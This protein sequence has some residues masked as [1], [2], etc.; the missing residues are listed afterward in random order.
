MGQGLIGVEVGVRDGRNALELLYSL[1]IKRLY[2]VDDLQP[3]FDAPVR[4]YTKEDQEE[5]FRKL[6]VNMKD[7]L[8][9]VVFIRQSSELAIKIFDGTPFDFV[10]IDGNHD[11][12]FVK[13][14]MEWQ[15]FL[16]TNGILGGHDYKS[17]C[18][19]HVGEVVDEFC[20]KNGITV[21][22]LGGRT[23][24]GGGVEWAIIK[25][26]PWNV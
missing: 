15:K 6:I 21:N 18:G 14:D 23:N 2:L 8:D 3:Y 12:D 9:K 26:K 19:E 22:D 17:Y 11:Y 13:K 7:Y 24:G 1:P 25:N 10:Y 5:E 4:Q 16:Q 20:E